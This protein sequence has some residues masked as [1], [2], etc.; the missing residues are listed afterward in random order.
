MVSRRNFSFLP[1]FF[2]TL[3]VVFVIAVIVRL[4]AYTPAAASESAPSESAAPTTTA[5]AA[6]R[7]PQEQY[8]IVEGPPKVVKSTVPQRKSAR[9]EAFE[10]LLRTSS[11]SQG[12]TIATASTGTTQQRVAP[13]APAPLSRTSA[14]TPRSVTPAQARPALTTTSSSA[15][16]VRS[17]DPG[18]TTSRGDTSKDPKDP[19]SDT[20]PPQLISVDFNP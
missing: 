19:T 6:V 10:R 13:P 12:T 7:R 4:R 20:T 9:D 11:A 2:T 16:P 15:K 1:V 14:A 18:Q 5:A 8:E 17:T 3:G